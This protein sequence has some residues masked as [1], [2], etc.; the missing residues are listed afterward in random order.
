MLKI[1]KQIFNSFLVSSDSQ[2]ELGQTMMR[3]QEYYENP[4][5]QGKIFSVKKFLEWYKKEYGTKTYYKD[6]HG[7]NFP[8]TVLKPFIDGLFNPLTKKEKELIE[9]F[10]G[11]KGDYYIIGANEKDILEHELCHALYY[12][13][14]KYR[15]SIKKVV[16]KNEPQLKSLKQYLIKLGYSK[17]VIVDEI[18][19]YILDGDFLGEAGVK[20]SSKLKNKIKKIYEQ[21]SGRRLCNH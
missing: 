4:F 5:W 11:K 17:S 19:A 7:F 14:K 20:I 10:K 15:E 3:F 2:K 6:W 13:N 16:S 8:S 18:Q 21:H 9:F 12:T 1:K